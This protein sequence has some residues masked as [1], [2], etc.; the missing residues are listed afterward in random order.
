MNHDRRGTANQAVP[1]HDH[2]T[3][4]VSELAAGPAPCRH[5]EP[6]R[7]VHCPGG[8]RDGNVGAGAAGGPDQGAAEIQDPA[9]GR[10]QRVEQDGNPPHGRCAGC[11][12][13]PRR[14]CNTG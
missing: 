14:R 4:A 12:R 11:D 6:R 8:H 2:R 10:L 7:R 1:A 13:G 5:S 3:G 9:G